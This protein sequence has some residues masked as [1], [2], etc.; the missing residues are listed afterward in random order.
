[1]KKSTQ[2]TTGE[3]GYDCSGTLFGMM[4][5]HLVFLLKLGVGVLRSREPEDV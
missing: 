4:D 1:M 5:F 3:F 2:I